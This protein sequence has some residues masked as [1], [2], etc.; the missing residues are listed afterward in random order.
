MQIRYIGS[1][2]PSEDEICTVFG[3]TFE[4]NRW[5]KLQPHM[6]KLV[7]NPMFEAK[8]DPKTKAPTTK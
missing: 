1:R 6:G 3:E 8:A 4:K 7:R 2:D 5:H